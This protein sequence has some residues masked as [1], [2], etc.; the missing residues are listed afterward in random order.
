MPIAPLMIYG[1]FIYP[2]YPD[3]NH[4]L[5]DDWYSHAMYGTFFLI[6]YLIGRDEGFWAEL[7]RLRAP[8][9]WSGDSFGVATSGTSVHRWHGRQGLTHHLIDPLTNRPAVTDVVQATVVAASTGLAEALAKSAVIR[10]SREGCALLDRAGAWA[11]LLLLEDDS[12]L[13]T[14]DTK[15]WLA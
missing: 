14:R 6:G 10:G 3:M 9:G 1:N 7:A 15:R 8:R 2:L 11:A 5:M 13:A 4:A 12:L